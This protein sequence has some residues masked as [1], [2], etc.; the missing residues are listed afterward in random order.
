MPSHSIA[1]NAASVGAT[2]GGDGLEGLGCDVARHLESAATTLSPIIQQN[3]THRAEIHGARL[4]RAN[5]CALRLDRKLEVL[6]A[7]TLTL[8]SSEPQVTIRTLGRT[9][10]S[11]A[12][13]PIAEHSA[14]G[15][16]VQKLVQ[17]RRAE[18]ASP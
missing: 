9:Y 2:T 17:T 18:S 16:L 14:I 3:I 10:W 15:T 12:L 8:S 1:A 11:N 13:S 7:R 5:L 4:D 6:W